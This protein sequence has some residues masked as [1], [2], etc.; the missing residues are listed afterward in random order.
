M[1]DETKPVDD[2]NSPEPSTDGSAGRRKHGNRRLIFLF[3]LLGLV[4][5]FWLGKRVYDE[6]R[7][8]AEQAAR[9]VLSERDFLVI[10]EP[11]S[12]FVT[13]VNFRGR[14]V[15]DASLRETAKLYHLISLGLAKTNI[16]D[17]Q[18]ALIRY[19][20][21][22]AS[23]DLSGTDISDAGLVPLESLRTLEA[24][25]LAN[26]SISDEGLPHTGRLPNLA[27]LDLSATR[28]TDEGLTALLGLGNLRWLL[29]AE[30]QI[31]DNGLK[32][33]AAM[34]GLRRVTLIGS[35]ATRGGADKLKAAVPGLSVDL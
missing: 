11:V 32:R 24:L 34:K 22:L 10:A 33:L 1:L 21:A 35:K 23:L 15:D 3:L 18:L 30:T 16:A 2:D 27:I 12:K 20:P 13:S 26:T 7:F 17:R 25:H 8:Q 5:G 6:S 19:L 14:D 29:L 9:A 28:V 4:A 31:S